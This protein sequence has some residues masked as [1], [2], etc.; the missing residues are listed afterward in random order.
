MVKMQ[1]QENSISV[2][3]YNVVTYTYGSGDNTILL[4]NGGPGL[5]CDY[6]R[7]PHIYLADKG[8]KVVAFDQLGCG[9]S[10]RP[11][12][13]SLWNISRYVEEV[14]IVRKGLNLKKVH[15]MGSSWGGWLSIEYS[16]TYTE[17]VHSLILYQ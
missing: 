15:L 3:G 2:D 17:N 11:K 10:D 6:L 16:L 1:A 8:Y 7:D 9:R 5:P 13:L 4:L 14:E 12:D